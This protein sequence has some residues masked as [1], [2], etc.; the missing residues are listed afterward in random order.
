MKKILFALFGLIMAV[1]CKSQMEFVYSAD[2]VGDA[3]GQV[4]VTFPDGR[5]AL[6]GNANLSFHY[7]NDS[8]KVESCIYTPEQVRLMGIKKAEPVLLGAEPY[9]D[10]FNVTSAGGTYDIVIKGYVKESLTGITF[11]ID[12]RFTNR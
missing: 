7:S 4:L 3:D 1:S 8:T 11:Q 6:N 9:M 10:A 2:V 12:K 5:F